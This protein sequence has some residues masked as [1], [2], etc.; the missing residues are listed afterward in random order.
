MVN[1]DLFYRRNGVKRPEHLMLPFIP[2]IDKF[3]FPFQSVHHF[4]PWDSVLDGPESG[5]YFYR[6]IEKKIFVEH[7]LELADHRGNPKKAPVPL[8]SFIR[9]FHMKNK[10][11]RFNEK[12]IETVNDQYTLVV[13]NYGLVAKGYRYVRSIY[14]EYFKW[15]NIQKTLWAKL[16]DTTSKSDKNNFIFVDLPEK[17]LGRSKLDQNSNMFSERT[18]RTTGGPNGWFILEMW[19]WLSAEYRSN[20]VIGN[21]PKDQLSKINLVIKDSGRFVLLNLGTLDSWRYVKGVTDVTTDENGNKIKVEQKVK[22][23]ASELQKRFL[24]LLMS[25][26][27]LRVSPTIEVEEEV[28]EDGEIIKPT[29][30]VP[31]VI[32]ANNDDD[33]KSLSQIAQDILDGLDDDIAVLDEL[34]L[35][36]DK[37]L[38]EENNK[39]QQIK[40]IDS[41]VVTGGKFDIRVFDTP[42]KPEDTIREMCDDLADAGI[43]TAGD[44]RRFLKLS[45]N[46]K[47]IPSPFGNKTLAEY[48]SVKPEELVIEKSH[49]F[50]D[51]PT[52]MDKSMLKN[53]LFEFDEKYIKNVLNK[54]IIGMVINAQK[55]GFV[56]NKYDVERVENISG[57]FD[58]HTVRV[59]LVEGLPSTIRF[60]IPV[61]EEDGT[62][63]S[64]LIKYKMRK[65]RKDLPLRK[66][67]PDSVALTTYFGKTFVTRNEKKVNDYGNWLRNKIMTK[68]IDSSD[69]SITKLVPANIFDNNFDGPRT[70]SSISMGYK[71]FDS[72]GYHFNFDRNSELFD[73]DIKKKYNKNGYVVLA[74]NDDGNHLVMDKNN[75]LYSV[76]ENGLD[77]KG[78]LESFIGIDTIDAPVDF[79]QVKIYG[80][81]LPVGLVLSYMYGLDRLME[82][83]KVNPRRVPAGQRLNLQENEF[84]VPFSD[85]TLIFSRDDQLASMIFGGFRDFEKSIKKYSVHTFD[86]KNV[87]LNV[88]ESQGIGVRYLREIEMF[89]N[90]FVDNI[91]ADLLTAKGLPTSFSGMLMKS[92]E[93]LLTDAHPDTLDMQHMRI[94]GY[95][96]LA[97]A[98][99]S[100]LTQALREHKTKSN[101]RHAQLD[102]SPHAVWKRIAT[103]PSVTVSSGIN[104]IKNIKES[105][106]VT[107]N[108]VGGRTSRSM[109]RSTRA[110]H[111]NDMGIISESTVDS[112]DVGIN[113]FLSADPQF[114]SLRGTS[115]K[116]EIGKTGVTALL[117]TSA[118]LSVGSTHDD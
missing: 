50:T 10:R 5:E 31:V 55:A 3:E 72:N 36:E 27:S 41:T 49:E 103:D 98:V 76:T 58:I 109:V 34:D 113:T 7:V 30:S 106:A 52:V 9:Q 22:I 80:K 110:Y 28:T 12:A 93:L 6:N 21:I 68:G 85:E 11:F 87:Y 96:R 47:Q 18:V 112:S 97:G 66:T 69:N 64:G 56:I 116:Y 57:K 4:V 32:D 73:E 39:E 105:E 111:K 117:S 91:S 29:S 95:E 26:M 15:W 16:A 63:T 33:E 62:Y 108:G 38:L 82:M 92:A 43:L 1:Y 24:K 65:M 17:L 20:S 8:N 54:D 94:V 70:H 37:A 86:K 84:A 81:N 40:I 99:Y 46:Y 88:F 60:N 42:M 71:S 67:A 45:E 14:A 115:K 90:L 100:E 53:S 107:Y 75:V 104:P 48:A 102:M 101:K 25:L 118:Q 51:I 78:T 79:A 23:E 13:V 77:P 59:T 89:D 44:Y 61:I 83:L 74:H 2:T 114:D 35:E 19:K